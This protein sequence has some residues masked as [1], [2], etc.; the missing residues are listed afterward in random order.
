MLLLLTILL[1]G[2][3]SAID[4]EEARWSAFTTPVFRHYGLDDGLSN[5][6]VT[7]VTED[8]D[9]FLWVASEGGLSRWDGYHFKAYLAD[10]ADNAA[11]TDNF[12]RVLHLDKAGKLWV[13]TNSGGLVRYDQGS[14][15]FIRFGGVGAHSAVRA[16]ADDGPDQIWVGT[17]SGVF[18]MNRITGDARKLSGLPSDDVWAVLKDGKG[19]LWIGTSAGLVWLDEQ[20]GDL[21]P[22]PIS[23]APGDPVRVRSLFE[24]GNGRMWIG[25]FGRG[26]FLLESDLSAARPIAETGPAPH[27]LPHAK[28]YDILDVR[29]GEIWFATMGDGVVVLDTAHGTTRHLHRDYGRANSLAH[30]MVWAFYR[31]QAG[32]VWIG[33]AGGLSRYDPVDRGVSMLLGGEE[34]PTPDDVLSLLAAEDGRVWFGSSRGFAT[35]LA[36]LGGQVQDLQATARFDPAVPRQAAIYAIEQDHQTLYLGTDEGLFRTSTTGEAVEAV[37]VPGRRAANWVWA[38]LQD[39][40][41]LWIGGVGDGLWRYDTEHQSVKAHFS[42]GQLT[43]SRISVLLKDGPQSLWIGTWNG[44]NRLDLETGAIEHITPQAGPAGLLSGGLVL[45]LTLDR[46][47]RLWVGTLG[48]GIDILERALAGWRRVAHIGVDQGL[49]NGGICKLVP[50][51]SGRIWASTGDGLAVIDPDD[52]TVRGLR[53]ADGVAV[54]SFWAGS[55]VKTQAGELIFGGVG[56][57]VIVRP[58]LIKSRS[59]Q[60]RLVLTDLRVGG[61]AIPLGRAEDVSRH[62]PLILSPSANSLSIEFSLLDF[63]A[64]DKNRFSYWMEN[65]DRDWID[66]DALHR[67]VSYTNLPPGRYILHVKGSNQPGAWEHSTLDLPLLVRPAW[68]QALWFKLLLVGLALLLGWAVVHLRT[69]SLRRYR[70]DLE[71]EVA[72]RTLELDRLAN[73]DSL[74]GLSNRRHF[75]HHADIAVSRSKRYQHP[76]SVFLVD[77][78]YFKRINDSCGHAGGDAV[79]TAVAH[80]LKQALRETDLGARYG[81]EELIVLLPETDAEGAVSLAERFR[82]AVEEL[83]IPHEGRAIHVTASI[84]VSGWRPSEDSISQAIER[85]DQALYRAKDSGRNRTVADFAPAE[86]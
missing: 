55:G 65:F 80:C 36:P 4:A 17:E 49:P 46:Q 31:D 75:F 7:S 22:V 37:S 69:A 5:Q 13:G 47:G 58:D 72:M 19:R 26:A 66:T 6:N 10:P 52:F 32:A 3:W 2:P 67:T 85:A 18:Q 54:R 57:A 8:S 51:D 29:P 82:R 79:L 64:P 44:L 24:D 20:G 34:S 77:L 42:A 1:T 35:V 63:A 11:L 74:T 27:V 21:H 16:I 41:D 68:H 53:Q 60:A 71:A 78:D 62:E 81:G 9:G 76:L 33:S 45:A 70:Q 39:G 23:A 50:D 40:S 59:Y 15:H 25:T 38:L 28:I 86:S 12:V 14:D 30:D 73:S 43:D 56:G 61:R 84:G 48:G 83:P